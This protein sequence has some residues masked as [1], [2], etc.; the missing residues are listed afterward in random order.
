[1]LGQVELGLTRLGWAVVVEEREFNV[2]SEF[3][4]TKTF[5]EATL[6]CIFSY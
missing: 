3:S 4:G 1:M 2:F 6:L 5:Q